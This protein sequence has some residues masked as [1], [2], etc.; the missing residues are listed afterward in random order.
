MPN[1]LTPTILWHDF[2]DSLELY[3]VTL[4]ERY[5]EGI[6][7]ESVNFYGRETG[8][9][10][11]KIYGVFATSEFVPSKETV[12]IFPDSSDGI[13]ID[14]LKM[15]VQ[16]GY[17][18][19]MVDYRGEWEGSEYS[20]VYPDNVGYANTVNCGRAKDFVDESA[21]KT[22]WYEWV[23]V[24]IYARKFIVQRTG[25]E[26]IA[27][28]GLR[29]GGE[30]AWKLAVAKKFSCV[31]PVCAAGWQAYSGVSKFKSDEQ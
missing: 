27:V 19:F 24:G 29:D 3:E 22:S 23:A 2:D 21:V 12:L 6:K 18:A 28:V 1:I 7:F 5:E 16:K 30:I 26:N 17:S 8:E 14:I 9:G 11:V 15:F 31:I 10:R 4:K 25:S 20:T 13:D